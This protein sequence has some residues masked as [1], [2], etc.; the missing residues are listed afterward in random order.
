M[1]DRIKSKINSFRSVRFR[2]LNL[3]VRRSNEGLGSNTKYLYSAIE[4]INDLKM[5]GLLNPSNK[6][7]DFGCGQGRLVNGL[8]Y[9]NKYIGT[10]YGIDT[11]LDSINWCKRFLPS[12]FNFIHLN[13]YNAR[14]NKKAK[15][16]KH[17]PLNGKFDL[18]F[19]NS[20]FSHMIIEDIEFY[21]S[22][23]NRLLR[24]N[25]A[26]YLT[27]FIESNVSNMEENPLN[28]ISESKEPLHRVRYDKTYFYKKVEEAGFSVSIFLY[29]HIVRAKQSVL[30]L[31]KKT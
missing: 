18:I 5:F 29:Q 3:P 19:L 22:E 16:L 23:F 15:G 11:N 7:L 13:A 14:Y 21:L 20:V 24:D 30:I 12:S 4:Q 6:I 10:Y 27:A 1:I 25:G 28:Y 8:I 2:N 31:T 9:T 26:I 17:I